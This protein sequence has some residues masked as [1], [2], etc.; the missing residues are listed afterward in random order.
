MSRSDINVRQHPPPLG[1]GNRDESRQRT[2]EGDKNSQHP[3][4]N[5]GCTAV[6]IIDIKG[7]ELYIK[8]A[9]YTVEA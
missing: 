8:T 4:Q 3:S 7:A 5:A 1:T 6:S 2:S 9:C